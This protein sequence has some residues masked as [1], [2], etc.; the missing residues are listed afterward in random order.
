MHDL[1]YEAGDGAR[2][3]RPR[4]SLDEAQLRVADV[5]RAH[6]GDNCLKIGLPGKSILGYY[7]QENRTSR[8]P[9]LLLRISFPG[10]PIFIQFIPGHTLDDARLH[11][12]EV[13]DRRLVSYG[14]REI[15]GPAAN[16]KLLGARRED[17][18]K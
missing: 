5:G 18:L 10:R 15:L 2:L 14:L 7:F 6:P 11:L 1:Q 4:G 12:V 13:L 17:R 8:R 16:I 9:F 3:S